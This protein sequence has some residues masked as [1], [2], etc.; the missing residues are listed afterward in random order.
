M[1][2]GRKPILLRV[3]FYLERLLRTLLRT[4]PEICHTMK[5]AIRLGF[6]ELLRNP[7]V[8]RK[9]RLKPA[10]RFGHRHVTGEHA[11]RYAH[12]FYR[13]GDPCACKLERASEPGPAAA[14]SQAPQ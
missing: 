7:A 6:G 8:A 2:I 5:Q 1:E 10:C 4:E 14:F 3:Y 9:H 11:P 12:R 13:V